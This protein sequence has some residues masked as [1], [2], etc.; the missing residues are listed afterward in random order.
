MLCWATAFA[1]STYWQ[2]PSFIFWHQHRGLILI[3]CSQAFKFF[4]DGLIRNTF[5]D[6]CSQIG[7][8]FHCVA[9]ITLKLNQSVCLS[10]ANTGCTGELVAVPKDAELTTA[11]TK[12]HEV[13]RMRTDTVFLNKSHTCCSFQSRIGRNLSI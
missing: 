8:T 10:V 1:K 4:S 2:F 6:E 7:V 9:E 13:A 12:A 3:G 5:L 11:S